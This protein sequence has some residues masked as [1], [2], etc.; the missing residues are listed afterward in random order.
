MVPDQ[1]RILKWDMLLEKPGNQID[2]AP[3]CGEIAEAKKV[4]LAQFL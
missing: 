3:I 1:E 4:G 2:S